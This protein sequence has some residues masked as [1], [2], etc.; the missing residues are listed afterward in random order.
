MITECHRSQE[1]HSPEHCEWQFS[2]SSVPQAVAGVGSVKTESGLAET[3]AGPA[4]PSVEQAV[5][6]VH[7]AAAVEPEPWWWK[8]GTKRSTCW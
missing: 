3:S 4:A 7:V 2:A 5:F 1:R 6:H 8:M